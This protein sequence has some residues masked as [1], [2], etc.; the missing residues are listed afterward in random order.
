[1]K[2]SGEISFTPLSLAGLCEA[3]MTTP[4]R[5]PIS[6]VMWAMAGVGRTPPSTTFTPWERRPAAR[7]A[8]IIGPLVRVSR[9]IRTR[10]RTMGRLNAFAD[11]YP[12]R[13]V[14]AGAA[15][16]KMPR[17]FRSSQPIA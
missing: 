5:A 17:S 6:R 10:S 16:E 2:P 3:L 12:V 4:R 9:P 15:V 1:L 13:G 7:A 8:L 14:R 11:E